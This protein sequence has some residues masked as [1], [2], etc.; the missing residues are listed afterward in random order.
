[1]LD[2]MSEDR[3]EESRGHK[4][5]STICMGNLPIDV[6]P[7][8]LTNLWGALFSTWDPAPFTS[9]TPSIILRSCD[10]GSECKRGQ[11]ASLIR[12]EASENISEFL[13]CSKLRRE[14]QG[15][16]HNLRRRMVNHPPASRINLK[17]Y[18]IQLLSYKTKFHNK[19]PTTKNNKLS[20]GHALERPLHRY[21]LPSGQLMSLML[22]QVVSNPFMI[23]HSQYI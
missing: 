11:F 7:Y 22:W 10:V 9:G 4:F 1:M 14:S 21:E 6:P 13:V 5:C 16:L 15:I 19:Q 8:F 3:A 12:S 23:E 2:L 18:N 17:Y 20:T